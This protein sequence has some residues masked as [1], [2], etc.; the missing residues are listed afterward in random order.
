VTTD[1]VDIPAQSFLMGSDDALAYPDDGEGPVRR[2]EVAA[3]AIEAR[4]VSN[5][6][7]AEFV[8][9]TGHV[10]DAERF[11][12]SFVFAGLLPDDHPPTGAVVGA[13]WWR[14]VIGARWDRPYGPASSLDGL[15]DHPVVH[16]SANDADA[17]CAWAGRRLPTEAEWELAAR[18]G[19]EGQ[20][21]PWGDELE[22]G[23]KHRMNVWQGRFPATNTKADGHYATAPV[24]A[25]EPNGLGLYNMTGNVWEWTASAFGPARP[26]QLALRGGSY[27]CHASYCRR[28]RTSA[29]MA[30]TRDTSTGN[31][32]FRCCAT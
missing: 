6:R 3:F 9:A 25:Y 16:V 11:D 14:E 8:A 4:A 20:P 24:D 31:I 22:P 30:N 18:G 32:G 10:T 28:Y 17:F 15:D 29:R 26:G 13:E 23:G 21:F 27:L 2:V 7:F 5:A 12:S 1:L 19:L